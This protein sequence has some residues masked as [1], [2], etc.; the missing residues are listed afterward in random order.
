MKAKRERSRA[1]DREEKQRSRWKLPWWRGWD[2][3]DPWEENAISVAQNVTE[4]I[5]HS[6]RPEMRR[7]LDVDKK[8]IS[9]DVVPGG[10]ER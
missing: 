1:S 7:V 4:Q 5:F 2:N 10:V 6:V 9:S 3:E 8:D